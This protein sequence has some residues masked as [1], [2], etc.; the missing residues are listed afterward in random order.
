[1][2]RERQNSLTFKVSGTETEEENKCEK[3]SVY[4]ENQTQ[5]LSF[6]RQALYPYATTTAMPS[7]LLLLFYGQHL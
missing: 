5:D 7:V 2:V 1:M 6:W 4:A 3:I